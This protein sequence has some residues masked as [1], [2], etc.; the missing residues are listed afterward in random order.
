MTD[1]AT[2][3]DR[4]VTP[5][6][7]A[8]LVTL[9]GFLA[10]A[11]AGNGGVFEYPLD[12]VYIH[13][14]MA[15]RIASGGYGVN[16]GEYASAASSP[17]Y[18]LLLTPFAGSGAQRWLPLFW[19]AVS[20][21]VAAGLLAT[22]LREAGIGRAAF[23]LVIAAPAALSLYGTAYAGMEN[24]AHTAASL[25]I[26]LGLWRFATFGRVGWLLLGGVFLAPAFRIEG[27]ALAFAAGG[28]VA[29][30]G[31]PL[32]GAGLIALAAVPVAV[33][34]G[35]LTMLGLDALPN[36]VVA[37]LSDQGSGG[38]GILARAS[39][40]LANN[41][42]AYGGRYLLALCVV[43]AVVSIGTLMKDR[44]AGYIGLAVAAAGLAHLAFGS[45]GWLDRYENYAVVSAFAVLALLL[46]PASDFLKT[47]VLTVAL[48]GGFLTYGPY[49]DNNMANMRAINQQQSQMARLAKDYVKVPVALNDIGYVAW[50]NPNYVLDLWGLAN[51]D[52]LSF[53]LAGDCKTWVD[54]LADNHGVQL[55][56]IY[57]DWLFCNLGPNWQKIGVLS[58]TAPG[59]FLGGPDVS[60]YARN[61]ELA[62]ELTRQVKEWMPGLPEGATF[63]MAGAK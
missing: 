6:I 38:G 63:T 22:I 53:R 37:K 13:L 46:R 24:M 10:V 60:F 47:G 23:W 2:Y 3:P 32:A 57:D 17:A 40:N 61:A 45:V 28:V 62:P 1:H 44:R 14:A 8:A 56:M 7:V 31:R 25:A 55:A 59:A 50:Q 12:D 41:A 39:A 18:P 33:F 51:G 20:L 49:V 19:N 58:V 42:S 43:V 5:A 9:A 15:E 30:L 11:M 36:S 27:L 16:A 29:L 48:V 52:A 35:F 4:I 34:A 54:V 26:V 21:V